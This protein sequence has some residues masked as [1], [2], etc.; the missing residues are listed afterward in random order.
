LKRAAPGDATARTRGLLLLAFLLVL[1]LV[2]NGTQWIVLRRVTES[3][4]AEL[5][6]RLVTVA[7]AGVGMAE[8]ELLL[9]GDV[10]DNPFVRLQLDELRRRHA[11]ADVFLLDPDGILLFDLDGGPVGDTNPFLEMDFEAFSR[12]V[13]GVPAA[14]G[15]VDV[16]GAL[17]KAAYAPVRLDDD[18]PDSPVEAVLGVT[19]GGDFHERLPT[20]RRRLM[21]ISIGSGVLVVLLG[22]VFVRMLHRLARTENAL[23]R[24]ETL[25][26]MGMMAAGVAHE[27]R[28]PLAI[29]A[30][31][32][33]RLKSRYGAQ[34]DDPLFDSISEEVERLNGILE[35]YLRFARDE[36]LSFVEADLAGLVERSASLVREEFAERDVRVET[37]GTASPHPLRADPQRLQQVLLNLLLNSAQ[38]IGEGG[39]VRM[40][41]TTAGDVHRLDVEDDGPGFD[42]RALR[43][44]FQPFFTTKEQGSGLGL[45]MARRIVEGHGGRIALANRDGG[46][47]R[48]TVELPRGGPAQPEE[49]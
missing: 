17:L 22:V 26:A 20:L 37:S 11:L 41:L 34:G 38:A 18:D 19:A 4:E 13:A 31:T 2:V 23:V 7:Q 21:G 29:I 43:G 47:A 25:G 35:G 1:V 49:G 39:V 40:Q 9:A 15:F 48:V 45:V 36:P 8:P 16:D 24:S 42:A 44:A 3:V 6:L 5:G 10:G 27:V 30:G 46:G 14:S 33:Q 12:A 28:N 32:A